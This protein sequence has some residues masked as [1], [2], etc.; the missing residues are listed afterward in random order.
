MKINAELIFR[1]R[2]EKCWSQEELAIASGLN[3]RT[4]QRVESE[5]TASLQSKKAI[6]S[7]LELDV[8]DLDYIEQPK[9]K[10]YEYK[11][12]ELPFKFGIFKQGTPDIDEPLN[13]AG[14]EGWRL[15]QMVVPASSN[16]G[17]SERMVAILE[18]E[19]IE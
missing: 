19:L 1:M 16:L 5:A 15:S 3:L 14:A 17:Q 6:A 10:K 12:I 2:E 9:M 11:T 8:R 7:A 4:I 18:R 13:K